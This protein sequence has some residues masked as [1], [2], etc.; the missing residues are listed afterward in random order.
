LNVSLKP[1][2]AS[3][4]VYEP[5]TLLLEA[6]GEIQLPEVFS[7]NGFSVTGITPV[8]TNRVRIEMIAEES[9]ILTV[10]P[11]TVVSGNETNQTAPLRLA[12]SAPRRA[13]EMELSIALSSTNLYTDQPVKM[14]VTW[15]SKVPFTRCNELILELPIL[16]NPDWAVYPLDPEV[17]EKER[18]GLPVNNQRVI[19]RKISTEAGD[20]LTFFFMLVPRHAGLT[21]PSAARLSCALM[22]D[23]R[24]SSQYPSYFDNHF[25]NRPEKSDR[26]ERIYLSAPQAGLTVQ[27]LPDAGRTARYCGIVG[28]CTATASVQ[29]AE[30]VVG[31]PMLLNVELKDLAFGEQIKAL[32]D[33]VIE[34]IGSEFQITARPMHETA[35]ENSRSFTYVLRPLRSGITTV[36]AL[37]LQI[38]DPEQKIYRT[39]RTEPLSIRVDSDG[40]QTVYQPHLSEDRKPKNPLTGIRGNWKES[41][42]HMNTYGTVEFVAHNAWAFWLLPPLLGLALRPWFRRRDRCRTDPAYARALRAVRNFRHA[43]KQDEETAWKGYLAD[44]FDLNADTVTFETIAP[45]LENQNVPDD[46]RQAVRDRF[47][48]HDTKHYAPQG[49]PPRKAPSVCEL[50]R[51]IEKTA[52]ILLLLI[53]LLGAFNTT[54]ATP[55]QLFEQAMQRRTEKPDEAQPLFTEAALGFEAETEFLNAGN[56]WFFAGEN[57]RALANYLAA[58][59]RIPFNRQVR[60]SIAFIRAQRVDSFQTS[61]SSTAA[62]QR[63]AARGSHLWV[64][65]CRWEPS[66]RIGLLTF[67]YLTGW[68]LFLTARFTGKTVPRRGWIVLGIVALI[69]ALSLLAS[70]FPRHSLA[71]ASGWQPLE[72][73]VIQSTE[74]R[75]GPGY[76]YDKAYDTILHE[77]TEFQ[78]LESRNGWIH[79]RMPDK[80]EAWISEP[81]C[82]KVQ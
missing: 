12:I 64:A 23:R 38:F 44:R 65:F 79:A 73:V 69:P 52:P 9:G 68:A 2:E 49:T 62:S 10:P 28:P 82:M 29:P 45:E 80:S 42:L 15:S 39:L 74:A 6:N 5:F 56:S 27:A 75:L 13:E 4:F 17:P 78:W 26:F 47:L 14:T 11:I 25:F 7:G 21:R 24:A 59:S 18:I 20:Q 57:G 36:P 3:L 1:E 33:A 60:E 63:F 48:R 37:A 30:T 41:R 43:V 53:C 70:L 32:P 67:V 76:A 8:Q 58:E 55:D 40:K 54:A 22:Q 16:L 66:I 77:A 35:T 71:L 61:E 50:V 81:A 46:L 51:K 34:G 19:A 31:Q 72:G